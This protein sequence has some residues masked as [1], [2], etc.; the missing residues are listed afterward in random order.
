MPA[1]SDRR[2]VRAVAFTLPAVAAVTVLAFSSAASAAP[3]ATSPATPAAA[4][5]AGAAEPV[6]RFTTLPFKR[7]TAAGPRRAAA[8]APVTPLPLWSSRFVTRGT[9]YTYT[10]VGTSP[11]GVATTTRITSTVNPVSLVFADKHVVRPTPALVAA[12][13]NTGLYSSKAFPGGTGQYGD[14]YLRTQFWKALSNGT[15]NWHVVMRAPTMKPQL[16]LTVPATKGGKHRLANGQTLYLVDVAWFDSKLAAPV[17]AAATSTLTQ[18][19]G[20][21]VVLCGRYT[22]RDLSSCGIGGYHSGVDAADGPHTYLYASYLTPKYFGKVSGFYYLS[23]MSHELAEW[24]T[25]PLLDNTVPKWTAANAA[26]YG[27]SSLL[28]VGDPLVGKNIT[29]GPQVY[30][31]EAYLPFFI[32]L[33]TST[34]WNKRYSWFG[35]LKT[36]SRSC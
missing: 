3:Q 31:D 8:A 18:F 17:G 9:P 25:D 5:G 1:L 16:T 26:Q 22:P 15:K 21:E 36:Y 34:S 23:P 24:L 6:A 29:V 20:G 2:V 28:E 32:R 30:Q 14:V 4:T 19:L 13:H 35:T 27:C 12:L 10:M 33:K 11:S 7:S